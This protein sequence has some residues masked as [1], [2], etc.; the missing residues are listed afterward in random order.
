MMY[1][2]ITMYLP[3]TIQ[4]KV[5]YLPTIEHRKRRKLREYK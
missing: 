3:K 5:N 1:L 4:S 2:F